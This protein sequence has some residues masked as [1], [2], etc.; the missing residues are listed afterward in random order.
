VKFRCWREEIDFV[1]KSESA[2]SATDLFITYSAVEGD[3][4][5]LAASFRCQNPI[6][7]RQGRVMPHVLIVAAIK[8]NA[9]ITA[10]V[11]LKFYNASPH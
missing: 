6:S 10:M 2:L 3:T 11:A 8:R 1:A 9:I 4:D 5:L 7:S